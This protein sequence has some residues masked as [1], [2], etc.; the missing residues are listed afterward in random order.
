MA[1]FPSTESMLSDLAKVEGLDFFWQTL[2]LAMSVDA[3]FY[4]SGERDVIES[5]MTRYTITEA[6]KAYLEGKNG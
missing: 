2:A 1:E 4:T 5:V 6:G 3:S